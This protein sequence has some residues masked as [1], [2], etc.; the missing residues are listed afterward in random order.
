MHIWPAEV[1]VLVGSAQARLE[2]ERAQ[3]WQYVRGPRMSRRA[4]C[5]SGSTLGLRVVWDAFEEVSDL[6]GRR[7]A[8]C[9]GECSVQAGRRQSRLA[10][11]GRARLDHHTRPADWTHQMTDQEGRSTSASRPTATLQRRSY[12]SA[13]RRAVSNDAERPT[14][15]RRQRGLG[16][17][18]G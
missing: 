7:T 8:C 4:A 18:D 3:C 16:L 10:R 2:G 11:G 15:C 12:P 1:L 14:S 9:A 17:V 13:T 6:S 5:R